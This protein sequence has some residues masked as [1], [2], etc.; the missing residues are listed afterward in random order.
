MDRTLAPS[1]GLNSPDPDDRFRRRLWLS[2]CGMALLIAGMLCG[3]VV[4]GLRDPAG[5]RSLGQDLLPGYVA[6][7]LVRSGRYRE[8]YDPTAVARCEAE[9]M[10]DADLAGDARHG[11]WV[12]P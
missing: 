5:P 11:V 6:G 4:H 12:N 7:L 8:L 9:V 2:L 10:R 1:P 3:E